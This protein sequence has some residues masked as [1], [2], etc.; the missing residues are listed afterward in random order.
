MTSSLGIKQRVAI[1]TS[2][3][4]VTCCL[5]WLLSNQV[6]IWVPMNSWTL[7]KLAW[8]KWI[9]IQFILIILWNPSYIHWVWA[10]LVF[11]SV[12]WLLRQT[13]V[14]LESTIS[15][16][17]SSS[18]WQLPSSSS[19]NLSSNLISI[20]LSQPRVQIYYARID[21]NPSIWIQL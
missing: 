18:Y 10:E 19:L 13:W 6:Q 12:Q 5:V 11:S 8:I 3:L 17:N 14:E 7:T 15:I 16:S 21:C 1:G 4:W 20:L 2:L 9:R